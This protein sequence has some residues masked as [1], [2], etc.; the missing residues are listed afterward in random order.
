[1]R[2][3][4]TWVGQ[5]IGLSLA[6]TCLAVS[7]LVRTVH[8]AGDAS[9]IPLRFI[10]ALR[11]RGYGDT[12]VEYLDQLEAAKQLPPELADS[13][14]LKR[15]EL[16][17]VAADKSPDAE[18]RERL[19]AKSREFRQKFVQSH[20]GHPAVIAV[21]LEEIQRAADEA[22]RE[23]AR[24]QRDTTDKKKELLKAARESLKAARSRFAAAELEFR[25]KAPGASSGEKPAAA[26][27]PAANE[28]PGDDASLSETARAGI[29]ECQLNFAILTYQI[30]L[31]YTDISDPER[32][33]AFT[34]A[35]EQLAGLHTSYGGTS[36][37]GIRAHVWSGKVAEDRGNL[38]DA[39]DI[40]DEALVLEPE[41]GDLS[42]Q[43]FDFFAQVFL[44][45]IRLQAKLDKEQ[46]VIFD[47]GEWMKTHERFQD[48]PAFIAVKLET[49]KT[50]LAHKDKVAS[51]FRARMQREAMSMLV[52]VSRVDTPYRAEALALRRQY[53]NSQTPSSGTEL[54][55]SAASAEEAGRLPEALDAYEKGLKSAENT[56]DTNAAAEAKQGIDRVRYAMAV[57]AF[58]AK[59]MEKAYLL[60]GELVQKSTNELT[61]SLSAG[62]ALAAA[63]TLHQR[64]GEADRPARLAKLETVAR[65]ILDH[66]PAANDADEARV[67]LAQIQ[68]S[69]GDV[70]GAAKLFAEIRPE[71]KRYAAAMLMAGKMNL[72]S[73]LE[74]R[75]KE[76]NAT[77]E[78]QAHL[79]KAVLLLTASARAFDRQTKPDSAPSAQWLDAQICLGQAMI[80]AKKYPDASTSL[81][82]ATDK[83]G[84]AADSPDKAAIEQLCAL[85]IRASTLGG[86]LAQAGKAA[87]LLAK[88]GA[89]TQEVN[90]QL[91]SYSSALQKEIRK[92]SAPG[93]EG[94]PAGGTPAAAKQPAAE[95]LRK[96][97]AALLGQLSKRKQLSAAGMAFVGNACSELNLNAE[98][99][100]VYERILN[101]AVAEPEFRESDQKL[102][103]S[104]RVRFVDILRAEGKYP[105]AVKEA[106][107]LIDDN[108]KALEPRQL[109]ART[110]QAWAIKDPAHYDAAVAAWTNVRMLLGRIQKKPPEYYEATYNAALCLIYQAGTSKD[111]SKAQQAEQLLNTAMT[112]APNLNGPETVQRYKSLLERA[113]EEKKKL[114]AR[115]K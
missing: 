81:S 105:E 10:D 58:E 26:E 71:S 27:K 47:A 30:A 8:A 73:Y 15:S 36:D 94:I 37:I 25:G 67:V 3:R 93:G 1:M 76:G 111:A 89:D 103:N 34:S 12:A 114:A 77:A 5:R 87:E 97:Q 62:V 55:A 70:A 11:D 69:R 92:I 43:S 49:A 86:N 38:Q 88:L 109:K 4:F 102:I 6:I 33:E 56:K 40:Y 50:I 74:T 44:F 22:Q 85:T 21:S 68:H 112:L 96:A 28:K 57:Q 7:A 31:T 115:P 80:E 75:P 51:T 106:D 16:L 82:A 100:A 104:V 39:M 113:S 32:T 95:A 91:L 53:L 72:A 48:R 23:L 65:Y 83:V 9:A 14:D 78:N 13:L 59:D 46:E 84:Q 66:W 99:R 19:L 63:R 24:A 35:A 98:A 20:P 45:R 108:P 110:L 41:A 17:Q 18:S 2:Q 101:R 54:M 90:S 61:K 60:A 64:A 79:E 107:R 42:A 29:G 52:E